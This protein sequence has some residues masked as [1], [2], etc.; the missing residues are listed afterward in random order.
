[1]FFPCCTSSVFGFLFPLCPFSLL[2][3]SL[4]LF[5]FFVLPFFCSLYLSRF[6]FLPFSFPFFCSSFFSLSLSFPLRSSPF[7]F[8]VFLFFLFPPFPS[9]SFWF[10]PF[11]LFSSFPLSPSP[12]PSP[13]PS[14]L[15]FLVSLVVFYALLFAN[16]KLLCSCCKDSLSTILDMRVKEFLMNVHTMA[17]TAWNPEIPCCFRPEI[18]QQGILRRQTFG[19]RNCTWKLCRRKGTGIVETHACPMA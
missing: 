8:P 12:S 4:F 13:S 18:S 11:F 15:F 16:K 1:M 14:F 10:F 17:H 7:F 6:A 2:L 3:F 19:N 5:R 9:F